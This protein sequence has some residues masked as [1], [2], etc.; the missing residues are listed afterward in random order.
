MKNKPIP[1][2]TPL[3]HIEIIL[4]NSITLF[5]NDSCKFCS[6]VNEYLNKE[7]LNFFL[8]LIFCSIFK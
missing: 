3:P 4:K 5:V 1:I 6:Y 8:I 7:F 2:K